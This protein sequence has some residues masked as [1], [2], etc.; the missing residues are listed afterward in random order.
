MVTFWNAL[1]SG[2]A[3]SP[4]EGKKNESIKKTASANR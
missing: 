4:K 3:L 1:L 2:L